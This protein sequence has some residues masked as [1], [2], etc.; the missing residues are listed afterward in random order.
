MQ[1]SWSASVPDFLVTGTDTGVGKTVIA[2]ALVTALRARGVRAIGFK[3]VQTGHAPGEVSDA[4]WLA[5]ASTEQTELSAP[6]LDLAEPLAPAAAADRAGK[7][8]CARDIDARVELLRGAGFTL[9]VEGAGGVMVPLVWGYTVLDLAEKFALE[10]VVVGRAGLGTLNH[11]AMTVAMQQS[12][13]ILIRA[14]VLNGRKDP[15]DLAE[16]TNPSALAR[17]LPGLAIVE[18]PHQAKPTPADVIAAV[19]PFV[20]QVIVS[21]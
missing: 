1:P 15:P 9:V 6:L 16:S 11:V 8:V 13:H 19:V 4:D 2:A 18:V 10:A 14:V 21:R 3:P 7:V 17:L 20:H 5:S 12:S